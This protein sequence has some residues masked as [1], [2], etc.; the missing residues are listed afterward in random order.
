MRNARTGPICIYGQ[1]MPW[2][3]CANAQADQGLRCPLI[4][5]M[6]MCSICQRTEN[7]QIRLYKC[8]RSFEASPFTYGIRSFFA[9]AVKWRKNILWRMCPMKTRI[10]L[11]NS[12][13][14]SEYSLFARRNCASS[15]I[16][17]AHSEDSVQTLRLHR[18]TWI[19]AA[20]IC[21]KVCL[22]T[23]RLT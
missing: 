10:G 9:W 13:V 15:A 23:L 16:E 18:L 4:E 14:R 1:R 22:L 21:P 8:A 5:L 12:A 2:S 7:V 6:E 17:N 3:A 19:F 20:H 11:C